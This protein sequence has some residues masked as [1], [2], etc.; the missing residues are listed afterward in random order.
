MLSLGAALG[1]LQVFVC[2]LVALASSQEV[3]VLFVG[4]AEKGLILCLFQSSDS[5]PESLLCRRLVV[6][7]GVCPDEYKLHL[8]GGMVILNCLRDRQGLAR[9][10]NSLLILA[11][12]DVERD[13]K[14]QR[15]AARAGIVPLPGL[16]QVLLEECAC[17]IVP[18]QLNQFLCLA[19]EQVQAF[20]AVPAFRFGREGVDGIFA[21]EVGDGQAQALGQEP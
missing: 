17:L 6:I 1:S 7:R 2:L 12:G 21:Q 16:L 14:A 19:A 4:L 3:A 9:C 8:P 15:H 11:L 18:A 5:P 10:L 20:L 13:K